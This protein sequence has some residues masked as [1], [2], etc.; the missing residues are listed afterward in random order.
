MFEIN[1]EDWIESSVFLFFLG[2]KIGYSFPQDSRL[3]VSLL[4]TFLTV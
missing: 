1:V 4:Q 3:K 2:E